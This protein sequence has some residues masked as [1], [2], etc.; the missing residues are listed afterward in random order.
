EELR[1]FE[2]PSPDF[3]DNYRIEAILRE[4][5][6]PREQIL[7]SLTSRKYDDIMAFYLLLGLR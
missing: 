7:D 1:P 5:N 6:Y 2:E 3:T 4:T